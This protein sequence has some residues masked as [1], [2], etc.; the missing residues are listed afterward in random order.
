[1][2]KR[3]YLK[4]YDMPFRNILEYATTSSAPELLEAKLNEYGKVLIEKNALQTMQKI[5]SKK[6]K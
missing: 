4:T 3:Y 1:M 2:H 6:K 5:F